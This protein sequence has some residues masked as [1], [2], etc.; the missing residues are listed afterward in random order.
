MPEEERQG[1]LK[2]PTH[3]EGSGLRHLAAS[4]GCLQDSSEIQV[5]WGL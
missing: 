2:A 3:P 1:A 5:G 4:S